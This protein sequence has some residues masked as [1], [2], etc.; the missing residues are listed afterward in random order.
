MT[1]YAAGYAT[2][3]TT[4]N[5]SF[6]SLQP[7]ANTWTA[8]SLAMIASWVRS[9]LTSGCAIE[10]ALLVVGPEEHFDVPNYVW[11]AALNAIYLLASTSWL[12]HW[13]FDRNHLHRAVCYCFQFYEETAKVLAEIAA[14][15]PR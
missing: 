1:A 8:F 5:E 3:T 10:S 13:V 6:A 11:L 4:A 2:T 12:F 9:Y 15:L 7:P 14:F